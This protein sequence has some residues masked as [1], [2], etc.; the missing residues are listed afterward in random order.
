MSV[1]YGLSSNVNSMALGDVNG[2]ARPDAIIAS[3][4]SGTVTV[5]LNEGNGAFGPLFRYASG[6]F[7]LA[8][9]IGDLDGDG[10]ADVAVSNGERNVNVLL[11][12]GDGAF[13]PAVDYPA[14]L[15]YAIIL[16]DLDGDGRAD[17]VVA[18][19]PVPGA[20]GDIAVLLNNGDG[21]FA[22]AAR[23][24]MGTLE[25]PF[26]VAG[27]DLDGDGDVDLVVLG[28][29]QRTA[30]VLFNDGQGTFGP[31]I[32]YPTNEAPGAVTIGDLDGDG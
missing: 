25:N 9:A 28:I 30:G 3:E 21:T 5:L 27:G 20:V 2:D 12:S 17:L 32:L 6:R 4:S 18:N 10:A 16:R 24:P 1:T 22:T 31:A 19:E 7:P 14:G 29:G 23:Y 26:L 13:A 11:N 15:S 8:A